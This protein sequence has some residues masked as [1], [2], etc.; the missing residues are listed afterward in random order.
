MNQKRL[1]VLLVPAD[2]IHAGA[3]IAINVAKNCPD[4]D[5]YFFAGQD[6][7]KKP[8][9]FLD[10]MNKMD[11]VHFIINLSNINFTEDIDLNALK[12]VTIATVHHLCDGE[13]Y[14]YEAAKKTDLIHT[15][16]REWDQILRMQYAENPFLAHLGVDIEKFSQNITKRP[17]E[18]LRIGMFG[19]YT[20]L[21]NRKRMDV[22]I[23]GLVKLR[24]KN[25]PY[26]L[27]IQGIISPNIQESLEENQISYTY[28]GFSDIETAFNMYGKIDCYIITSDVEGGP[29]SIL[30]AMASGVPVISTP[31]G[32]SIE[33]IKDKINGLLIPK[34]DPESLAQA[35]CTLSEDKKLYKK[36]VANAHETVSMYSWKIINTEYL[37]LYNKAIE[38]SPKD[39]SHTANYH[40]DPLKQQK[41]ALNRGLLRE[42]IQ[43][44]QFKQYGLAFRLFTKVVRAGYFDKAVYIDFLKKIKNLFICL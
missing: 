26:H 30:E 31:V 29:F 25:I 28:T 40:I 17:Q 42:A 2:F 11:I 22:A 4:F 41:E 9:E 21:Q 19:F 12:C 27:I 36:I 37:N 14:K 8:H 32:L 23:Q 33:L 16:S 24:S 35:I 10:L 44:A 6:V 1:K 5:F 34:G 15:I 18:T 39:T 7:P 3:N 20:D 13:E 38:I 43:L